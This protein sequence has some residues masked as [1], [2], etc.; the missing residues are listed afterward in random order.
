[1]LGL[2]TARSLRASLLRIC[3]PC[4]LLSILGLVPQPL[5]V[6]MQRPNFFAV[7]VRHR[8][9][10]ALGA[11]IDAI[12]YNAFVKFAF[13]RLYQG[14]HI[15]MGQPPPCTANGWA[16]KVPQA[17]TC[18]GCASKHPKR[19][20]PKD[21]LRRVTLQ[22]TK[23]RCAQAKGEDCAGQS[24]NHFPAPFC[25]PDS[26]ILGPRHCWDIGCC[27]RLLP[28]KMFIGMCPRDAK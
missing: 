15:A 25:S 18:N 9:G 20:N 26:E 13:A 1:M 3:S 12:A 27:S 6:L 17:C 5:T 2:G 24:G 23:V 11:R 14:Q 22:G 8:V 19:V 21:G 10:R 7:E 16:Q 28:D 4:R